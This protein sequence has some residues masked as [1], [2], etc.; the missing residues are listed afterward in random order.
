MIRIDFPGLFLGVLAGVI[1]LY[2]TVNPSE[3]IVVYPTPSN[4]G[5]VQ[6]MDKAGICYMYDKKYVKCGADSKTTPIQ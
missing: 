1:A 3:T 6:Y 4:V 5:K 2:T